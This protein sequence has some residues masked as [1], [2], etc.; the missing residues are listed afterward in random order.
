[1]I[2]VVWSLKRGSIL[3]PEPLPPEESERIERLWWN[4]D[5]P[6]KIERVGYWK[7]L[8]DDARWMDRL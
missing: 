3:P 2:I 7:T 8:E 1:M 4:Q 6:P 5:H